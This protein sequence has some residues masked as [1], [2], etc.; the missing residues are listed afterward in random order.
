MTRRRLGH[1]RIGMPPDPDVNGLASKRWEAPR[2]RDG[3]G[4]DAGYPAPPGSSEAL[5]RPGSYGT[6]RADFRHYVLQELIHNTVT[7]RHKR[8]NSHIQNR[9]KHWNSNRNE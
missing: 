4:R 6:Q 3:R 5:T 2:T 1:Y 9:R 7:T 8:S